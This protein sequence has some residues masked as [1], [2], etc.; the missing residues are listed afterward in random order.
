[1]KFEYEITEFRFRLYHKMH[2][3]DLSIILFFIYDL[4]VRRL[5]MPQT[6]SSITPHL[7][8]RASGGSLGQSQLQGFK[9]LRR[10]N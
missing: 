3:F 8:T 9:C 2:L 10:Q 6:L 4:V 5:P 7:T 1:M